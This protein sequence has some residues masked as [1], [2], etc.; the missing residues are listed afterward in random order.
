MEK[1][2]LFIEQIYKSQANFILIKLK[3]MKAKKFQNKLKEY[4]ILIRNCSNF[5]YLNKYHIRIAVKNRNYLF[6]LKQ[7]LDEL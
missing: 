3:N 6:K 4:K 1:L 7:A 2:R 5:D